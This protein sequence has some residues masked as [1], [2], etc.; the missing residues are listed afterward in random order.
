[1]FPERRVNNHPARVA[2]ASGRDGRDDDGQSSAPL[3]GIASHCIVVGAHHD[4]L[5]PSRVT[6]TPRVMPSMMTSEPRAP[7]EVG[8]TPNGSR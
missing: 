8:A 5:N 7:S 2:T 6:V 3:S 1:M 4:C